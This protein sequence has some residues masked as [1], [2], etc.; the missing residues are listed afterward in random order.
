MSLPHL[1][2][3]FLPLLDSALLVLAHELGIAEEEGFTLGLTRESSWANI[4]DRTA[5]GHFDIALVLAPMPIA[6]NLGLTPIAT[7]MIAPVMTGLGN[8]AITVSADLWARMEDAGAPGDLGAGPAGKALAQVVRSKGRK[9]RFGVVHQTS[10]HNYEL[11]YWLA[12]S[13]IVPDRDVEIVV[14]PPPLLPEAL[15]AGSLDGYCV[16]EPWNSVGVARF[17]ARMA[18]TKSS[19]WQWSPDKAIGM[20]S[21]WADA[22]PDLVAATI[23]A[24]YRAGQWCQDS[25]NHLRAAEIMAGPAY[26]NQP[27]EIVS[28][29]LTG[30]IDGGA[31]QVSIPDFYVPHAGAANFPWKSH[32]LWYYSQM[33][34][35]GEVGFSTASAAIAA[36]T[37]R[38]DLYRAAL[39]PLGVAVP[40]QDMRIDGDQADKHATP[41]TGG[42]LELGPNLF[43]D[44]QIFDPDAIESYI[45]TQAAD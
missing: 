3:G 21:D 45:R 6:A 37:F 24:V 18:T 22:N 5:L 33:V 20:R 15:G 32:G 35:W 38:P 31:Q 27:V 12:A 36:N 19:I 43:F 23:R 25:A 4:R 14:L 30:Q 41:A 17:G 9:L 16:G 39:A 28:R 42:T 10:S 11:R 26:L 13:G 7:P 2:A 1:T 44:G 29:A 34:R 40:A 8:N